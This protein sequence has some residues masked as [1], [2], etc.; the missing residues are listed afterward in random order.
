MNYRS[1]ILPPFVAFPFNADLAES[2]KLFFSNLGLT[3]NKPLDFAP[4]S[5]FGSAAEL[6]LQFAIEFFGP[7]SL[8]LVLAIELLKMEF[9]TDTF[10]IPVRRS[11][12]CF[13]STPMALNT[14]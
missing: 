11:I 12:V 5:T 4:F 2:S 9:V 14:Q 6:K 3:Y 10:T 8:K 13:S 1:P 7:E